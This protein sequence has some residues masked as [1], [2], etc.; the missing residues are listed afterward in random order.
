MDL[1]FDRPLERRVFKEEGVAVKDVADRGAKGLG[2]R[3]FA[4]MGIRCGLRERFVQAFDFLGNLFDG[5]RLMR[6]DYA[7]G[8]DRSESAMLT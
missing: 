7:F 8:V 3:L 1:R 5:N 4:D 6:N 2:Q